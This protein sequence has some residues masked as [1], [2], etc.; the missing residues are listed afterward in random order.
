MPGGDSIAAW[1]R[2]LQGKP[3]P[4]EEMAANNQ[5]QIQSAQQLGESFKS[6]DD[7]LA[8]LRSQAG[9]DP[10]SR[11]ILFNYL[12]SEQS[13]S[14]ARQW[15]ER[16][17]STR[18]QQMVADLKKA[19]INPYW[20]GSLGG[21]AT[22]QGSQNKYSGSAYES[23]YRDKNDAQRKEIQSVGTVLSLIGSA[24]AMAIAFI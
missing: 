9:K 7:V 22:Y 18:Y 3:Q 15:E 12:L 6:A 11:D 1:I 23:A 8:Y 14:S 10:A 17:N 20:L 19:G 13:A 2:D 16:Q 5:K 24:I 4:Y 21:A